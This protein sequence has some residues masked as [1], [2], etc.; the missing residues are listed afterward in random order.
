MTTSQRSHLGKCVK[1]LK[2]VGATPE[3][4]RARAGRYR[5]VMP[6]ADLTPAALVKHWGRLEPVRDGYR[7]A[8]WMDY[9]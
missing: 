6:R 4:I 2:E 8:P 7:A 9:A 3:D 5:E 1:E